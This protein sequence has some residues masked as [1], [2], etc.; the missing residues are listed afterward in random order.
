MTREQF[1]N[2]YYQDAI[3]ATR[4]TPIFPDTVITAGGLESN[5]GESQLT[6]NYNNFFGFKASANW[7]GAT[8]SLPTKEVVN[9]NT[10]TVNALFRVYDS[11]QD[12]FADY[13]RLLQTAHYVNA[14][15]TDA[16]DPVEQ[17]QALQKAGY[18]TDPNYSSKLSSVY[19]SVKG[20]FTNAVTF[21]KTTQQ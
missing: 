21:F 14:G 11:P 1:V 17:F 16:T 18:A 20:F 6:K 5:W 7:H 15:V 2:L 12:S 19:Y 13:V 8:V 3:N 4:N 9:G 10:I